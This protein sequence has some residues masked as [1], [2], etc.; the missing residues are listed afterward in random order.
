MEHSFTGH[1]LAGALIATL[2]TAAIKACCSVTSRE[3]KDCLRVKLRRLW[4]ED[5]II[6]MLRAKHPPV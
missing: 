1:A 2:L 3:W 5:E 4:A 6:R